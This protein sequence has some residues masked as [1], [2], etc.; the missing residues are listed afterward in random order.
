MK[1]ALKLFCLATAVFPL[2]CSGADASKIANWVNKNTAGQMDISFD[3]SNDAMKFFV[4]FPKEVKDRWAYPF[5]NLDKATDANASK[6]SFEIKVTTE[7][8]QA[9]YSNMLVML[10]PAGDSPKKS[11]MIPFSIPV[12][13]E[14]HKV[15]VDISTYPAYAVTHVRIGMNFRKADR[16]TFFIRNV[17]FEK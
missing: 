5:L 15:T 13:D 17:R 7:P 14:F 2:L 11:I 16:A 6:I 9:E 1:T 3:S 8:E 12:S 4:T 10:Q